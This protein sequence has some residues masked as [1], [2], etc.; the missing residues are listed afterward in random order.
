[1]SNPF[2]VVTNVTAAQILEVL[3]VRKIIETK[4]NNSGLL[5]AFGGSQEAVRNQAPEE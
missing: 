3:L 2:D 4:R 5:T 1:M